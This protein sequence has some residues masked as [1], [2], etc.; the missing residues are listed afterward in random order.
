MDWA[1]RFHSSKLEGGPQ[2]PEASKQFF[3]IR[4]LVGLIRVYISMGDRWGYIFPRRREE[5][6]KREKERRG[7]S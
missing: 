2:A 3:R 7:K 4:V 5:K 1:L 6:R